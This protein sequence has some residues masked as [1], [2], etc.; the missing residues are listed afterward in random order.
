[1]LLEH[2]FKV[3]LKLIFDKYDNATLKISKWDMKIYEF[4][5]KNVL[6]NDFEIET[7]TTKLLQNKTI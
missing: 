5:C 4:K 2:L 3:A 6:P 7:L 1:M